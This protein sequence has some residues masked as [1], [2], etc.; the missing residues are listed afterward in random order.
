MADLNFPFPTQLFIDGKLVDG[1]SSTRHTL[2]NPFDNSVICT[3]VQYATAEDADLAVAA[4]TTAFTA[5]SWRSFTGAQRGQALLKLAD[6]MLANSEELCWLEG[7]P[8]GKPMPIAKWELQIGVDILKYYAGWADKYAGESYPADDGY[9]K[10][11]RQEPLGVVAGILPWNGPIAIMCLKLGPALATGNTLIL[12]PSE[13][14]PFGAVRI[15]ELATSAGILPPG[16]LQVL[17]GAGATGDLL[18]RHMDVRKISFTGS[19][20]TGRLV[21]KA[22]TDSNLKRVTLELGGKSPAIIFDDCNLENAIQWATMAITANTG[23]AC[24]AASRVFVQ[25]GIKDRFV[26]GYV[27]A[28]KKA[29]E[30]LPPL[31]DQK[32]FERVSGFFERDA[33]KTEVLVGGARFGEKGWFW[34]PTVLWEP[35]RDAEVYKEEIFGPVSVVKVFKEEEEVVKWANE[36]EYGLMAGVFTQDINR[37][38]RVS[39]ALE[40]GVVGVNCVSYVN[41][42]APFGGAKQSGLGREMGHYALRA[43]T[44]PK[45]VL[46][47]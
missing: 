4:A 20:T 11:V 25:E 5:G 38:M 9:I 23:Q 33:G 2:H 19:V 46:I 39:A 41:V 30:G 3:D 43:Y 24:Y 40:S 21:Q 17:P 42:Q 37:A 6:L 27:A 12:K 26:E 7:L 31:A 8:I 44:E 22:A 18:A 15:A 14:T 32:Q 10:I 16:V 45:T 34:E 29:G 36:T 28:M 47:K 35:E 1:H 13:K